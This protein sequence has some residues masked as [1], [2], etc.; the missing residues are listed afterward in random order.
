MPNIALCHHKHYLA[1]FQLLWRVYQYYESKTM[2][3]QPFLVECVNS[4][5]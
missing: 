3:Q 4:F 2:R 5:I 1:Y